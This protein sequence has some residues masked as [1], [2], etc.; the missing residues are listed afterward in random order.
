MKY[1]LNLN[2]FEIKSKKNDIEEKEIKNN[3]DSINYKQLKPNINSK[4]KNNIS[5]IIYNI[6]NNKIIY[7]EPLIITQSNIDNC[8]MNL[9]LKKQCNEGETNELIKK[10]YEFEGDNISFNKNEINKI[11]ILLLNYIQLEK[12][13]I[14]MQTSLI[15]YKNKMSK[16]KEMI[17]LFNQKAM[18]R[19]NDSHA[20]IKKQIN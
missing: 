10:I 18:K 8:K 13:F 16:M 15:I 20:F 6:D 2:D 12:K 17:L 19:I 9:L 4:I 11:G 1:L 14:T 3:N 7:Q 5:P